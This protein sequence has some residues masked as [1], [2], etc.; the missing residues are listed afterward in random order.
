MDET[1]R[2]TAGQKESARYEAEQREAANQ[3][4]EQW[5]PEQPY[6]VALPVRQLVEYVFL[7]GSIDT[8]LQSMDA[9]QEGTKAHQRVQE[10]YGEQDRKEV[11]LSAEIASDGLRFVV[12]GRCDGLLATEPVPTIDEIKSTRADLGSLEDKPVHWAQALFYAYMYAG[13]EGLPAMGIQLTY[14][15][16]DTGETRRFYREASFAELE[17][18]IMH[19]VRQYAPYAKQRQR[20][21][22]KR[23]ASIAALAFPFD[24][25][26]AGQRKLAGAVYKT[27]EEGVSLYAKAP[28]GIGKT[29]STTYPAIKAMG[30]G[31]LKRLY[32]LTARTTTRAA[33]ED[34]LKHM[35]NRGLHVHSVTITAKEKICFQDE[36][37]CDKD[38][39]P[40]ADGYYDR[41]NGA[42][43]DM[44]E[45]E[46]IMS[47]STIEHYARKHT[48]CPFEMSL[49]A[50][51]AS[52]AVICDY[53]YVFDPRI[54]FKRQYAE[55]KKA[56]A[57]LVDEAHNLVDRARDMFSAELTRWPFQ[58][59][60]REQKN[61]NRGVYEASKAIN[62][63]FVALRKTIE[64]NKD[65]PIVADTL[66][67]EL[68]KL[69]ERFAQA[70]EKLLDGYG[71]AG[72]FGGNAASASGDGA[73]VPA[74]SEGGGDNTLLDAYFAVQQFLRTAKLYDE[75]FAT[76]AEITRLDMRVKLFCMDPSELLKESGKGYRSHVYFSATLTPVRYYMDMLGASDKDYTLALPSPFA[77]ERLRVGIHPIST[78]Y[79]DRN[80][81]YQPI[82]QLIADT[83]GKRKGNYFVFFP[84]YAYMKDV[85]DAYIKQEGASMD[86]EIKLQRT[87][88]SEE[89]RDAF[90]ADF[91]PGNNRTLV[92]F[93]V[94]GGV[95]SEGVDLPGDRLIGVI[96][97]GVGLPQLGLERN[98]LRDFFQRE[99]K[100]GYDYAYVIPGMNKVLQA[101][102]RLIRTETDSGIITLVDD[103]YRQPGYRRLL[104]EEW[105]ASLEVKNG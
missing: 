34:A 49:D 33:A 99:G 16:K 22:Q 56:T 104:P 102:G 47:R 15:H 100:N 97:V 46:T 76:F 88:M 43:L 32:Y 44:L 4:A 8:R 53:N 28:T 95:F 91:K 60:Q 12:D 81:S 103:R 84:S 65:R 93:A 30:S 70:A 87:D 77:S 63:Y 48:V 20:H 42:I 35:Q 11:Y 71:G 57:L 66:P 59:L 68:V 79:Q 41:I 17:E 10:T 1:K 27:I 13:Q 52:D 24:N 45:N 2:R 80:A 9:L 7:S 39:C 37:R 62:D 14:V 3:T 85:Y 29:I 5:E 25:Y 94:L 21:E 89:E 26:R 6:T 64:D 86:I 101:G 38:H 75:R 72:G 73:S 92:G 31:L 78:R 50:A 67:D 98:L 23:D 90:L 54:S 55:G 58:T 105:L 74:S 36:V 19:I 69:A 82:A 96:V 40:Y 61:G 83:V 51:Y 18:Q